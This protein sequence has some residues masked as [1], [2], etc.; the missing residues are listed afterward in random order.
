MS[1]WISLTSLLNLG[2]RPKWRIQLRRAPSKMMTSASFR[3]VDLAALILR[4]CES[5]TTPFP[6]GVGKNGIPV[7]LTRSLTYFSALPLAHPFPTIISG[8][9]W[10]PSKAIAFSTSSM[11]GPNLGGATKIGKF[12]GVSIVAVKT[13][14]GRS[15][16]TGPGRP[17]MEALTAFWTW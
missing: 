17:E 1:S 4:G 7:K 12:I 11:W 3:A 6:I 8:F 5:G 16:K 14:P 10:D 13:S 9:L 2:G 15:R